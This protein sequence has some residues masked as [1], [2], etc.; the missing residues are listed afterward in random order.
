MKAQNPGR[1][2]RIKWWRVIRQMSMTIRSA[3]ED[4]SVVLGELKFL[5]L[6]RSI[7]NFQ[8]NFVLHDAR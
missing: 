3:P 4:E 6:Q 5:A 1:A 7:N 8:A 2:P